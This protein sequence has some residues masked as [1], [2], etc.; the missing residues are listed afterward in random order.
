MG[1]IQ[2]VSKNGAVVF[3]AHTPDDAQKILSVNEDAL[4]VHIAVSGCC[5]LHFDRKTQSLRPCANDPLR[6]FGYAFCCKQ[7]QAAFEKANLPNLNQLFYDVVAV[8]NTKH[9][10]LGVSNPATP[11]LVE[12][13][14]EDFLPSYHLAIAHSTSFPLIYPVDLL[15][16][17]RNAFELNLA[18]RKKIDKDLDELRLWLELTETTIQAKVN[19]AGCTQA[20]YETFMSKLSMSILSA[21]KK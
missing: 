9:S 8:L 6:E 18:F 14:Y 15:D 20:Q 12:Q 16:N 3:E 19:S 13:F 5:G 10:V 21:R 1:I 2:T 4:V 7:E 17:I 11:K